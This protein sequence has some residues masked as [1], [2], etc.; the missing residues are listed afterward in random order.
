MN[1]KTRTGWK[2]CAAWLMKRLLLAVLAVAPLVAQEAPLRLTRLTGGVS[3][4]TD[5]Q[6]AGDGSNRLFIVQ[7]GGLIRIF[8]DGA[9]RPQPFLDI[10]AKTRGGGERGLLGLAFPPDYQRKQYFYVNYTDLAGHTVIARYRTSSN[11][12]V[13]DPASEA[14]LIPINQPF[15]NHN[16]GQLRFGRDGFLYIG[17]GDCGSAG[18]PQN[19]GQNRMALLGKML[20]VDVESDLAEVRTPPGNPFANNSAYH[21]HIWA[22]GLRNPWRYSFDRATGDLWIADVGQNRAEEVNF[23]PASSRGGEN[24]G[25]VL[26][27]GLQCFRAGCSMAGLTLPILEYGRGDGC[28]VTG[29]HIYRG[30]RSPGLRGTYLY[31]DFCSGSIWGVRREGQEWVNRLLLASGLP[32]STF[33]EDEAGEIYLGDYSGAV[34]HVAGSAAPAFTAAAAVNAA[35][36]AP[37]L[38]AGSIATLY[39]VGLVNAEGIVTAGAIPLPITLGGVAV[40]VGGRPAPL[41]AV[42]NVNGQEQ[43][44]FQVPHEA[45]G[46]AVSIIVTRDGVPSAPVEVPLLPA[47]PGVFTSNGTD[48]IVVRHADGTLVTRQRPLQR[49]E[50]ATFYSTGLGAVDNTPSTGAAGPRSPLAATRSLPQV[51]IGGVACEVLYSGLAPDLVGLYQ[52]NIRMPAGIAAG[53]REL[54]LTI[55]GAAGRSVTVPVQ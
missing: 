34:H 33:G 19:N 17:M 44:N 46:A 1:D 20:R 16:G 10:T 5:I 39:G 24:Y 26:M 23:Q 32:I 37:G 27:E 48:A 15:A 28:S 45:A 30:T 55:A 7:Q 2:A 47:Q 43:I 21:P 13:A 54:A 22:L 41:F 9:L 36:N 52:L 49:G 51:T 50:L 8:R 42:A 3:L 14:I 11:R 40:T 4:P 38:V 25:W 53:D 6:H 18:D 12:D 29:G 31:G 35:S